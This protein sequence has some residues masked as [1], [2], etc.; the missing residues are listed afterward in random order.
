MRVLWFTH[1]PS[2]SAK[3]LSNNPV[4]GGWSSSLEGELS[5]IP[6]VQLGIS[7]N[8]DRDI[9]SFTIKDTKYFPV[10][11]TSP[12][13]KINKLISRWKKPIKDEADIQPYLDVVHEFKPDVIHIFGTEGIFGLVISKVDVPCIIHIQGVLTICIKKWY[14]G[15]SS[16]D[17]L[18]YSKKWPLLK[19]FGNYHDYYVNKKLATREKRIFQQCKYFM[20]RTEWDRRMVSVLSPNAKYFHCDEIM[21]PGFYLEQSVQ[22]K[23]QPDYIILTTIRSPIYKGL[24]TVFECKKILNQLN[25]QRKIIWKIA[26][27]SQ[28]DEISN[29]IERKYRSSFNENGIQLLG[30]LHESELI[31]EMLR[32]DLFIH[33]SHIDN[34]PNSVCEAMMLGMAVIATSV[35]GIPNIIENNTEGLLVQDGDPYAM[36]GAI[37]EMQDNP[38]RAVSYGKNAQKKAL[39]RHDKNKIVKD[40]LN[41]YQSVLDPKTK[42]KYSQIEI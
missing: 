40:L 13:G 36:A 41:I 24:E 5:K 42:N 25:L 32:A 4:G 23:N 8:I 33:P 34:S 19:G 18:K 2:L 22:R 14:S 27:I 10:Y 31:K 1:A 35:G 17:V 39:S 9:K 3:Y 20:G 16:V 6:T 30:P 7:F 11:N 26:G 15:L 21:R 38:S 12:T 37:I 28:T 29:L